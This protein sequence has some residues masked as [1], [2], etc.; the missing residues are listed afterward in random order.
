MEDEAIEQVDKE[1]QNLEIETRK[2][3]GRPPKTTPKIE[4][5]ESVLN[6]LTANEMMQLI[7]SISSIFDFLHTKYIEWM[8]EAE[9]ARYASLYQ[10]ARQNILNEYMETISQFENKLNQLENAINS[11]KQIQQQPQMQMQLLQDPR[12]RALMLVIAETLLKD[13]KIY[14]KIRPFLVSTLMGDI[15]I[16]EGDSSGQTQ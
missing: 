6:K 3:R 5:P 11:L 2:R 10:S 14:E 9:G 15:S 12:I 8:E 1:L 7:R 16:G 4:I 13:N